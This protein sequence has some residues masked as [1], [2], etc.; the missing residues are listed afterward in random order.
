MI[1]GFLGGGFAVVDEVVLETVVV[2]VVVVVLAV[3]VVVVLLV[4]VDARWVVDGFDCGGLSVLEAAD[5]AL[6]DD[7]DAA[8]VVTVVAFAVAV[9]L[10]ST[11]WEMGFW[12]LCEPVAFTGTLLLLV[13]LLVA[14]F[15]ATGFP[16]AAGNSV[17]VTFGFSSAA[18]MFADWLVDGTFRLGTTGLANPGSP[19]L[20]TPF[21]A[22]M[23]C[24]LS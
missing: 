4:A 19:S 20:I 10:P 23:R 9:T 12:T 6:V 13:L 16:P 22:T 14:C 8:D 18:T 24:A 17:D 21:R 7:D 2:V 3:V 5:N 15:V 1:V 11:S